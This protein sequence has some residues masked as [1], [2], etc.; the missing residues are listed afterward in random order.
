MSRIP[1]YIREFYNFIHDLDLRSSF[2]LIIESLLSNFMEN[3]SGRT[4]KFVRFSYL[5]YMKDDSKKLTKSR[6]GITSDQPS[7]L[8]AIRKLDPNSDC[9]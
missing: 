7:L 1:R 5:Y 9:R 3:I 6:I 2:L 4:K 8:N